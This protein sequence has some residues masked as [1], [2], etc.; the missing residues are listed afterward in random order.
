MEQI[1]NYMEDAVLRHKLNDLTQKTFGFDFENWVTE[2]YFEGD[3]IPYSFMEHGKVVSNVSA[4]RMQ[5]IQN[6]VTR[7]FI[8][9]GTVMTDKAYQNQGLAKKLMEHVMAQYEGRCDGIYLFSDLG[10]LGFYQKLGFAEGLQY[11]YRL[12][13][14]ILQN[15]N[16]SAFRPAAQSDRNRY[17]DA[18]RQSEINSSLEQIN[19]FGLQMFYTA[20]LSNVYYA[21]DIDCFIVLKTEGSTWTLESIICKQHLPIKEILARLEGGYD[22]LLLGFSPCR[23]DKNLFDAA[24]FDGEDDYRLF[25]R[26]KA[27]ERI[28]KEKLFF[29]LLSHA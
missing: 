14:R 16:F 10:A 15:K 2:G 4:N 1:H 20:D 22:R 11:Q 7:E 28:E 8:Q 13:E 25:Y 24:P 21:A 18:V 27:L 12:R 26:G 5:F 29:P 3:Y 17:M 23:E 6:G 9:I 19:K